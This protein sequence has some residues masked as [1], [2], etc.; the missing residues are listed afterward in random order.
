MN[1]H[2]HLS[3]SG[4]MFLGSLL[5]LA[6]VIVDLTARFRRR[7]SRALAGWNL[8]PDQVNDLRELV[9]LDDLVNDQ[10]EEEAHS[11][12]TMR[13]I[14]QYGA[15]RLNGISVRRLNLLS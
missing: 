8:E 6:L 1:N 15:C 14:E 12:W 9:R 5:I 10:L 13:R 2:S 3:Q 11:Y 7:T 4:M